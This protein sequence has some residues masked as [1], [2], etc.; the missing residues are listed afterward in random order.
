MKVRVGII[1]LILSVVVWIDTSKSKD[2]DIDDA[3]KKPK[4][5]T[6]SQYYEPYQVDIKPNAAGYK[7][8][9]DISDIVN[10]NDIGQVFDLND[11]SSL[12]RQNGFA[13]LEPG[14]YSEFSSHDFDTL[15]RTFDLLKIPAFVT[16]DT[17]LFL[18]HTL[19]GDALKGIEESELSDIWLHNNDPQSQPFTVY[20]GDNRSFVRGLDLMAL[21]GSSEA[22]KILT[23]EGNTDHERYGFQ[24]NNLKDEINSLSHINWQ[25]NLYWSWLYCLQALFQEVSEGYP[26]FIRTQTWNR[27]QLNAALA[28]WTQLQDDVIRQYDPAEPQPAAIGITVPLAVPPPAP[29]GYV[30][31]N[32]LFWG[33]LLSLTRMTSK[34]MDNLNVLTPEAR[35]RF[36]EFEKLLKQILDIVSRQ[37]TRKRLSPENCDF[38]DKLPYILRRML[39]G[40]QDYGLATVFTANLHTNETDT[41]VVAQAVGDIDLIIVA[42]PMSD[43]KI[44]L[45]VGPVLSYYEFKNP[46]SEKSTDKS[47]RL[48]LNSSRRPKRP[49][50]YVPLLRLKNSSSGFTRL[51][52]H[53][54]DSWDPHWLRDGH[55]TFTIKDKDWNVD[56]YLINPDG[57]YVKKLTNFPD[58]HLHPHLSPDRKKIAFVKDDRPDNY[59]DIYVVNSDGSELK[60]LTDNNADNFSPCW[61]PNGEKIAFESG[62]YSN[63]EIYIMNADGSEKKRLTNDSADNSSPFWSPDGE[64]IAFESG[65]YPNHEIYIMNA[66]GRE[67]K[68]LTNDSADNSSPCWSPDGQQIVFVSD[69]DG[70]FEIYVMNAD[71]SEQK[72]L[73]NNRAPDRGPCWSPDGK[74]IAFTSTIAGNSGIFIMDLDNRNK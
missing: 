17:G 41:M 16:S 37:L 68:K 67:K 46:M 60:R 3:F 42:C 14:I 49:R 44:K 34:S 59:C 23:N 40:V 52:N 56:T 72:R 32:P 25:A 61:S 13:I 73:T 66:D 57:R 8:P 55:I 45:A 12:I 63:H 1:V 35:Q 24:I 64:K 38:F 22:L 21:L 5:I 30:E 9:L 69:R 26:E 27:R 33:R 58:I 15:Y 10:F 11:I 7:L 53:L 74:K 31:P 39:P 50:W 19:L 51:T 54:F 70:N 20:K 2:K 29:A 65:I 47:W 71:G 4:K 43:G 6:F 36:T 28:S 18:Y 62:N 48:I